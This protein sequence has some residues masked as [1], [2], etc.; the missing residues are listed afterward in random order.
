MTA[1][2]R[3]GFWEPARAMLVLGC[4]AVAC[5]AAGCGA[6]ITRAQ[7]EQYKAKGKVVV[8][9]AP[10]WHTKDMVGIRARDAD[11]EAVFGGPAPWR[12]DR[13]VWVQY[14]PQQMPFIYPMGIDQREM[15]DAIVR[16]SAERQLGLKFIA[17]G[18]SE[19]VSKRAGSTYWDLFSSH[20]LV[21][22]GTG[23]KIAKDEW[24]ALAQDGFAAVMLVEV[25][26]VWLF[27][28]SIS[29]WLGIVVIDT[30]TGT[31]VHRT[32]DL[33][34]RYQKPFPMDRLAPFFPEFSQSATI[35][36]IKD[37]VKAYH[38]LVSRNPEHL[39]WLKG[40]LHEVFIMAIDAEIAAMAK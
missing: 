20:D 33:S 31:I 34:G 28:E 29:M 4:A 7:V 5:S 25:R 37:D 3:W 14:Y 19:R 40:A 35:F 30:E 15:A 9:V 22:F 21:D 12:G 18:G 36:G 2:R 8:M 23:E 10:Q 39:G 13:L 16:Q 38:K 24:K 17:P 26:G 1:K 6:S 32:S 27:K 11:L